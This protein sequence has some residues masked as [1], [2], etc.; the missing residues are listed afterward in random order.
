MNLKDRIDA[1]HRK[2][3]EAVF[4]SA[5]E[6]TVIGRRDTGADVALRMLSVLVVSVPYLLAATGVWLL[7]VGFPHIL[8]MVVAAL[9]LW[10]AYFL[11]PHR[12]SLPEGALE[13]RD[14]PELFGVLD[15]IS[16]RLNA[17]D[18]SHVLIDDGF[19]ATVEST[20]NARLLTLG[21]PLWLALSSEERVALLAHEM[22]HLVN[23]DA[24]RKGA[25][26]QALDQLE[27][28][29]YLLAPE[30]GQNRLSGEVY[31][32]SH[33]F[34]AD[35]LGA[36][37]RGLVETLQF[38]LLRLSY[39]G[40]HRSEYLADALAARVAG[41]AATLG[42][43][44]KFILVDGAPPEL[45]GIEPRKGETGLIFL[46]RI[47]KVGIVSDPERQAELRAKHMEQRLAV[48]STHPPS[49]YR[50]AFVEALDIDCDAPAIEAPWVK[51]DS[52]LAPYFDRLGE[53]VLTLLERQ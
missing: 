2:Q 52:E 42:L 3:G 40:A 28:W 36:L 47:A 32:V 27:R 5:M 53:K 20:R 50:Q 15:A 4:L 7:W 48:N 31:K 49:C 6:D 11:R 8:V 18:I 13:R 38:T 10:L 23:N 14:L 46:Q 24:R 41:K 34:V 51:V 39:F 19:N 9:L 16:E 21:A 44:E 17:P 26:G 45:A 25:L 33:G 29:S 12:L 22:A 37:L 43:L 35:I 1:L 30:L